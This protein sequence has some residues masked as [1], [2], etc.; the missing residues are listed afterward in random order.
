MQQSCN[1]F[2]L[3]E[4]CYVQFSCNCFFNAALRGT[5][6]FN[7]EILSTTSYSL[8]NGQTINKQWTL[9]LLLFLIL[10]LQDCYNRDNYLDSHNCSSA[11]T[12]VFNF[13]PE[14]QYLRWW[15]KCWDL[16]YF[17]KSSKNTGKN[18]TSSHVK[19]LHSSWYLCNSSEVFTA[20][21]T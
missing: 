21:C 20:K 12:H 15:R 3:H 2:S 14:S 8:S 17:S 18:K 13:A 7:W 9:L 5:V 19:V 11:F 10:V 1:K 16:I 6:K 4:G